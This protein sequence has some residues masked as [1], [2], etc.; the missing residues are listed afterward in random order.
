MKEELVT[1]KTAK[2][3]KEK[4]FNE[5]CSV[6]YN[7]L[8]KTYIHKTKKYNHDFKKVTVTC[9]HSNQEFTNEKY[10]APTQS[11]LQKWLRERHGINVF[12]NYN[13]RR[14]G[15]LYNLHNLEFGNY[16]TSNPSFNTYEEALEEGLQQALKLIK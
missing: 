16:Y 7:S 2:L 3:A 11:L 4:G 6:T 1:F 9:T 13:Y 12:L 15:F 14:I 8:G 10:S 5:Q